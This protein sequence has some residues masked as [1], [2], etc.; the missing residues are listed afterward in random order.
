[1]SQIQDIESAIIERLR[2]KMPG[3]PVLAFAN[4]PLAHKNLQGP[5]LVLVSYRGSKLD[6][7]Q[8]ITAD[9]C[10]RRLYFEVA[11]LASSLRGQ[12][13]DAYALLDGLYGAL[14]GFAP[15]GCYPTRIER[16]EFDDQREGVW[17]YA[18]LFSVLTTMQPDPEEAVQGVELFVGVTAGTAPPD[19]YVHP[20]DLEAPQ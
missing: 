9:F 14:L 6:T 13:M 12:S 4:N 16:D 8:A 5:A 20:Q 10:E 2:A 15:P 19:D 17:Q 18:L 7:G 11:V 1:M 3:A